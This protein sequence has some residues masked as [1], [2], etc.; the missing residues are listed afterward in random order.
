[1]FGF[2]KKTHYDCGLKFGHWFRCV[3]SELVHADILSDQRVWTFRCEYC[4]YTFTYRED[5][6]VFRKH[7]T[8]MPGHLR[9]IAESSLKLTPQEPAHA[10][11]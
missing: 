1:M 8:S 5:E 7:G 4:G 3:S 11:A 10:D 9:K 6:Y 2:L